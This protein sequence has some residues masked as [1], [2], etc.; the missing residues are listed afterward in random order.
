LPSLFQYLNFKRVSDRRVEV[1]AEVRMTPAASAF[2]NYS[3]QGEPRPEGFAVSELNLPP[4]H[5]L[6]AGVRASRGRYFGH[7]SAS[8]V[9]AAFWQDVLPGYEGW[10]DRYTLIDGGV[11]VHSNDGALTIAVHGRNILNHPMQ[12]HVFGDVLRR[13]ITGEVRVQF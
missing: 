1:S 9:E 10:T 6:N 12:Q 11:G 13:A 8:I 3:W 4:E 5:R 7:V 2:A